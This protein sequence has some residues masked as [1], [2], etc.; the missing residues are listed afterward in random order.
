MK[1]IIVSIFC[2]SLYAASVQA[3]NKVP[4]SVSPV[5]TA[6]AATPQANGAT[7]APVVD[8]KAGKFKFKEETHDYG[9]VMEGPLAETDFEFKNVGKKP[10]IISE[11]HGSCGC[12]VP[13]FPKDPI[14]PNHKGVIHVTYNTTGR[15]G[16]INKDV[17][18]TSNAQQNPMKLHITGNVKPKPAEAKPEMA[19]PPAGNK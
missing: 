2:L 9:D 17:F 14:L 8:P 19:P 4:T 3:Q 11:A 16:M 18:I 6:A 12:T 10:I 1:K 5:P 15:V 13:S 7:A